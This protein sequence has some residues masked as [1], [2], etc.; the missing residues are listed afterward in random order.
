M[1]WKHTVWCCQHHELLPISTW[2]GT[3][4]SIFGLPTSSLQP[5]NCPHFLQ[6]DGQIWWGGIWKEILTRFFAE[7][8]RWSMESG[9]WLFQVFGQTIV[10]IT[11]HIIMHCRVHF[12]QL[13]LLLACAS[14][15][16]H[17]MSLL[18]F[19]NV[20]LHSDTTHP[21]QNQGIILKFPLQLIYQ[22]LRKGKK[23]QVFTPPCFKPHATMLHLH[24][25]PTPS[26]SIPLLP[27]LYP[28]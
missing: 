12:L 21:H 13:Q 25:L 18:H 16:L 8:G 7:Q 3:Q 24:P 23:M 1:E 26:L 14:A 4:C 27:P 17:K 5:F 15:L 20:S 22:N 6:G 9:I 2:D 11:S 28:S 19:W 10:D